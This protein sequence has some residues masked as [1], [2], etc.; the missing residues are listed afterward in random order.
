[1]CVHV[2]WGD[3]RGVSGPGADDGA[4][5]RL[6]EARSR[7]R[8]DTFDPAGV[9]DRLLASFDLLEVTVDLHERWVPAYE[10]RGDGEP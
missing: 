4:V 2:G 5:S 6:A 10:T 3:Q 9:R 1:M 8:P 7:L